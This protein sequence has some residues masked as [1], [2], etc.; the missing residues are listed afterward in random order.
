MGPAER[1]LLFVI[2]GLDPAIQL[3]CEE[4]MDARV[5]PGHDEKGK[6]P[7]ESKSAKTRGET[8]QNIPTGPETTAPEM[9]LPGSAKDWRTLSDLL[10]IWGLC[11]R[12]ACKRARACHGDSRRCIPRCSPLVPED[13]RIWVAALM[14]CKREG[15]CFDDARAQL[16]EDLE[17]AW[18]AW[19]EAVVR[20]AGRLR[21][22]VERDGLP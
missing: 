19:G 10:N 18:T 20:V 2:A 3:S 7:V 14:E 8:M 16:P 1:W 6:Q 13:A 15:L 4:K 9:R 21:G 11:G 17:D 12:S 22:A 5:K